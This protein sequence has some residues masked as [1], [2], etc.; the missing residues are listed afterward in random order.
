MKRIMIDSE[1]CQGCLSC[2]LACMSEHNEKGKSIYDLDLQDIKNVSKNYIIQ[3]KDNKNC[4][5]F[6][7]HCE[8]PECVIACMSGAM[9]KDSETGIVNYNKEKCAS[10]YMCVMSCPYGVLKSDEE[11]KKIIVKCDMCDGREIP[12]CVES[13]PTGAIYLV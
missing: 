13:C 12:R 4:P 3:N 11:T 10:C 2:S 7:R 8:E 6:C 1:K 5:M 9:T